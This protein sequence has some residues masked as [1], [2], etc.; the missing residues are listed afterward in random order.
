MENEGGFVQ[1]EGVCVCVCTACQ[2]GFL[3]CLS[4]SL[5]V[6]VVV[7]FT[8]Q[9]YPH[10]ERIQSAL[11]SLRFLHKDA[12]CLVSTDEATAITGRSP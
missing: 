1:A 7:V 11:R 2:G 5:V 12:D 9:K 6:V 10:G 3:V 4:D 8:V